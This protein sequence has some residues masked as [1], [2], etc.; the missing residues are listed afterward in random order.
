VLIIGLKDKK[1]TGGV[2][3]QSNREIHRLRQVIDRQ[4]NGHPTDTE[5]TTE[6]SAVQDGS[7]WGPYQFDVGLQ[8]LARTNTENFDPQLFKQSLQEPAPEVVRLVAF[9]HPTDGAAG[10]CRFAACPQP[11]K[12]KFEFLETITA[13]CVDEWYH[14]KR[15]MVSTDPETI[16]PFIIQH[17]LGDELITDLDYSVLNCPALDRLSGLPA[18]G[19]T[20]WFPARERTRTPAVFNMCDDSDESQDEETLT[21]EQLQTQLHNLHQLQRQIKGLPPPK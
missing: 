7:C 21:Y 3:G 4:R 18:G 12:T 2:L 20:G 9:F 15:L 14:N 8:H 13:N 1:D 6:Q 19:D 10:S 11:L 17:I 16:L 5:Q